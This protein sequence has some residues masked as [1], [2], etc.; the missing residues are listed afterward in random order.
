MLRDELVTGTAGNI[1]VRT[2]DEMVITPSSTP[3]HAISRDD[4]VVL[5]ARGTQIGGT[6]QPSAETPM[7]A[8]IYSATDA[9]AIVHTHSPTAVALSCVLDEL[10]AIH[11]AIA[12]FGGDTVRVAAY[13][14]FGSDDLAA[15]TLRALNGRRGALLRNHGTVTYGGSL[16]EAYELALLLEWLAEVYWKA[17]QIGEPTILSGAQLDEVVAEAKRRRYALGST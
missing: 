7:H 15:T 1:S 11:Y 9:A 4:L 2:E 14:R 12:R 13:E 16:D 17:R 8:A 5:D 6:G 10:P 3:Y